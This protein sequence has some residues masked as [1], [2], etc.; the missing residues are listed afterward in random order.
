MKRTTLISAAAL[1]A[2]LGST[3]A[4]FAAGDHGPKGDKMRRGAPMMIDFAAVDADGDGKITEAE[5]E[6]HKAA[7][8]AEIDA[9]GNGSVSAEE[10]KA[11]H[12]AKAQEREEQREERKEERKER[13]MDKMFERMDANEDGEL[14]LEELNTPAPKQSFFEKLDK[15]EDGFITEDELKAGGRKGGDKK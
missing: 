15:N 7:R 5:I 8:F 6:A 12:E 13:G 2:I 14:S 11:H 9:D 4:G 1:V 3:A 10:L